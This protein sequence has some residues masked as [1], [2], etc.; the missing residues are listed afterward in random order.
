MSW[1]PDAAH[2]PKVNEYPFPGRARVANLKES[3]GSSPPERLT[4]ILSWLDAGKLDPIQWRRIPVRGGLEV[5]V[6][7]DNI[8]SGA[9]RLVGPMAAAQHIADA[10]DALIPTAGIVDAIYKARDAT[11]PPQ[12][13]G[14]EVTKSDGTKSWKNPGGGKDWWLYYNDRLVAAG[15]PPTPGVIQSPLSKD[16]V[17][18]ARQDQH[19]DRCAIYGLHKTNGE[20]TQS[21]ETGASFIHEL[22]F[23]DYSHGIRLVSTTA[24][25]DGEEVSLPWI[26]QNRPELVSYKGLPVGP[27]PI[28]H[29][30][31]PRRKQPPKL[32]LVPSGIVPGYQPVVDI[33]PSET[34]KKKKG[35]GLGFVVA[36]AAA[37]WAFFFAGKKESSS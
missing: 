34:P 21:K 26:Y 5:A 22:P 25:L 19:P 20:P 12:T 28:R 17:L 35:L 3:P 23:F 2:A 6:S 10:N 4:H 27:I 24:W 9:V 32:A 13:I 31:I 29:P 30:A 37:V 15:L 36:A 16:Y 33:T 14:W 8:S 11:A 1:S 18:D 7:S